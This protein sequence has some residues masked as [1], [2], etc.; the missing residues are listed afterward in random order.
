MIRFIKQKLWHKKWMVVCL[1]IGNVLLMAIAASNPM[2]LNAALEKTLNSKYQEFI[3][4]ENEYPDNVNFEASMLAGRGMEEEFY[5]METYARNAAEA[6]GV[7]EKYFIRTITTNKL[8]GKYAMARGNKSTTKTIRLAAKTDMD[9]HWNILAGEGYTDTF[10][11]EGYI[12]VVISQRAMSKLDMVVGDV[13]TFEKITNEKGEP[14]SIQVVGVYEAKDETDAY[15]VKSPN[16]YYMELF[17]SPALFDSLFISKDN[18]RFNIECSWDLIYD[19]LKLKPN[20]VNH[21]VSH[22]ENYQK[23][24][25]KGRFSKMNDPKCLPML[26][27][28]QVES[29][30]VS[31]TLLILQIPVLSLLLAFIFM[32]SRQM[33]DL[34]QNEIALLKSRGSSRK[35]ILLIY[36]VQSTIL[37]VASCIVGIP[38]GYFLTQV[39]GST[40][41]FL[42]F[43]Q[44]KALHVV[45]GPG[46]FFYVLGA[47][48][49]SVAFMVLPVI[50]ESNV[51]IVNVKQK[52][53]DRTRSLW[54]KV[55]L[56]V[57]L[58]AVSLYGLYSFTSREDALVQDMLE[59]KA[60]DPFLFICSSLFII[61]AGLVA[62]RLQPLLIRVIFLI[63]RKYWKPSFFASFLQIIRTGK[64]QAFMMVFLMFTVALGLFNS[65]V[66]RTI[67]SNSEKNTRY[68]VGAD[69]VLKQPWESNALAVKD[70]PD[71]ELTYT[72][73]D[74][75]V[76]ESM[77]GVDK[78]T[79]VYVDDKITTS[80][81]SDTQGTES[82]TTLMAIDTKNFGETVSNFQT[83][84]LPVHINDYLNTL[85]KRGDAVLVSM[86]YH[87]R[88]GMEI[89]DKLSFTNEEGK[90]MDG[91][92]YGFIPYWPGYVQE[93][94]VVNEKNTLVTTQHYLIVGNLATVQQNFG[95]RPYQVWIKGKGSSQFIYDYAEKEGIE[96]TIFEDVAS[97]LVETK[98]DALF[99]GTNGILTMSFIV[100]LILCCT[101]FLIYWILSIRQRELLFGVFR[102]MGMSKKEIIQM[103]VNEQIF[104]TGLSLLI[105]TGIGLMASVW[106]VPLVQIFYSSTG[107]AVP[108]EVVNQGM[109]FVRLFSVIG[110]VIVVC[111]IILAKLISRINIS[112]ALKLGE[113]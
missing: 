52:K 42:E 97:K 67:L 111:M 50:R 68:T 24:V 101:G 28:Y 72:E 47:M 36:L 113:D 70:N 77:E 16:D 54:S 96:Y 88:Y 102:A 34:E 80:Y 21:V 8:R 83:E 106:F 81:Q 29:K 55:Y 10:T 31:T 35:Q 33:L 18:Q 25:S 26:R 78:A 92:I 27:E 109:D 64:K 82:D 39:L 60:I 58:L 1:L 20:R 23:E 13:I 108:L 99:Q 4:E 69:L 87:T 66:A 51:T 38:L 105:G 3:Q 11:R 48:M 12:P 19:Y 107:Q 53:H 74:F 100:I 32:I 103:L 17:L 5:A 61:S 14:V 7:K 76:Y 93:T 9:Q 104:S 41:G 110:I 112:Q 57:I 59:G 15:W 30:K 2:Y 84:L 73:P 40:N 44:R 6:I 62:L 94:T 22:M 56:D 86:N 98:N 71:L 85:G 45:I 79:K 63:G 95:M 91:I 90:E 89:G 49:V 37:A 46:V 43:I 75:G 65:T